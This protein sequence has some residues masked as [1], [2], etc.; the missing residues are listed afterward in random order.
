M[1]LGPTFSQPEKG[2]VTRKGAQ[3]EVD[4]FHLAT[5]TV[6]APRPAISK[7]SLILLVRIVAYEK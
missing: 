3:E 1:G 5:F 7:I 4:I 2:L 6:L